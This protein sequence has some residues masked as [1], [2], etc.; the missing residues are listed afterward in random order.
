MMNFSNFDCVVSQE[1]VNDERK[2]IKA[3]VETEYST[4]V[5]EELFLASNSAT[6]E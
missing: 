3:S 1:V 5:V 6:A 2:V 4:I